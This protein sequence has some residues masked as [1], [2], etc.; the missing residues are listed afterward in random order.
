MFFQDVSSGDERPPES[1]ARY[2]AVN[3]LLNNAED[4][5]F[6]QESDPSFG[7]VIID[8]CNI[9]DKTVL[10]FHPVSLAGADEEDIFANRF[11]GECTVAALPAE[12][13][14]TVWGISLDEV[15]PR[16]FGRAVISGLVPAWF[17]GKGKYV[18]PETA[19]LTAGGSGA[20]QVIADAVNYDG[21]LRKN[22]YPGIILLGGG[23]LADVY[24]GLFKLAA[25]SQTQLK[26]ISGSEPD[27]V[28]FCGGSDVPGFFRIP[29]MTMEL[30]QNIRHKIY[31]Y[32]DYDKDQKK[33]TVHLGTSIPNGIVLYKYL[34]EFYNGAVVQSYKENSYLKFADIWYLTP[35]ES[36]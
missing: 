20:A 19:G 18:T 27:N 36:A 6:T 24:N 4:F 1:A 25:L 2:N 22:S 31:I 13:G 28:D 17:I 29:Q 33:Y 12:N 14:D 16:E 23:A 30:A 5:S 8:F 7:R 21:T 9:S 34:G 26:I 35:E 3:R 32:F 11:S 15:L 10:P